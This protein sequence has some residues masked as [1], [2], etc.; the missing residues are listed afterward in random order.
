[1]KTLSSVLLIAIAMPAQAEYVLDYSNEPFYVTPGPDVT[2]DVPRF[3]G[4]CVGS[5]CKAGVGQSGFAPIAGQSRFGAY[6][7]YSSFVTGNTSSGIDDPR[8][9]HLVGFGALNVAGG[10]MAARQAD[11]RLFGRAV[12]VPKP[13]KEYYIAK[14]NDIF[15]DLSTRQTPQSVP[16]LQL[17]PFPTS[18]E[19]R[20][21]SYSHW[22][23][24]MP[25]NAKN[26]DGYIYNEGAKADR[27]F[28]SELRSELANIEA[29]VKPIH[30]AIAEKIEDISAP[31]SHSAIAASNEAHAHAVRL[32]NQKQGSSAKKPL[33]I[34]WA[35]L[36]SE[37]KITCSRKA[38][39]AVWPSMV[40]IRP[41]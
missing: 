36:P 17:P 4:M 20:N 19:V 26:R 39:S 6:G 35:R 38:R 14:L 25:D 21:T 40:D 31:A 9:Q 22:N 23:R 7:E 16:L 12:S 10:M 2:F 5:G 24:V 32:I 27:Y 28:A 8:V 18:E 30:Q 11:E 34:Q 15:Q 33:E 1:M 13:I 37:L 41:Y 3:D 29:E